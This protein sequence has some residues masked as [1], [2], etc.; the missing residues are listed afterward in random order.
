MRQMRV[1]RCKVVGPCG[2]CGQV[3]EHSYQVCASEQELL[4]CG[5]CLESFV[6]QVVWLLQQEEPNV[7]AIP[8]RLAIGM[9]AEQR[10]SRCLDLLA[11]HLMTYRQLWGDRRAGPPSSSKP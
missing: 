9:S 1:S 4:L 8:S 7:A 3:L 6:S 2:E 11:A 10:C 5:R